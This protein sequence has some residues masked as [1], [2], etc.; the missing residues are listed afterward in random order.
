MI[1]P[2]VVVYPDSGKVGVRQNP[3][4]SPPGGRRE[5]FFSSDQID[6]WEGETAPEDSR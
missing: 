1:G 3:P 5:N 4:G 6:Y 2:E